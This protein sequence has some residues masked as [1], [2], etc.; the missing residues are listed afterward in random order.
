MNKLNKNVAWMQ[1]L[2]GLVFALVGL[3]QLGSIIGAATFSQ[4]FNIEQ[5][6]LIQI[7]L[8]S[9]GIFGGYLFIS[10]LKKLKLQHD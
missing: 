10:T 4:V 7:G 6:S 1:V 3:F 2:L 9:S 8:I 5:I